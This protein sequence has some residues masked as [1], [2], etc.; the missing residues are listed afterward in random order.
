MDQ[1]PAGLGSLLA[2]WECR[3]RSMLCVSS[4]STLWYV[5]SYTMCDEKWILFFPSFF[6]WGPWWSCSLH[7]AHRPNPASLF[8]CKRSTCAEVLRGVFHSCYVSQALKTKLENY[9]LLYKNRSDFN[10]RGPSGL[11]PLVT[12]HSKLFLNLFLVT[13]GPFICFNQKDFK[14]DLTNSVAPEP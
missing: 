9:V 1:G 6:S 10:R 8:R 2:H 5:S 14:K 12:R 13:V 11:L 7:G 3:A 4:L